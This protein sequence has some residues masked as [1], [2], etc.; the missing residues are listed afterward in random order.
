MKDYVSPVQTPYKGNGGST[1]TIE[2]HP[3]YGMMGLSR[4][5]GRVCLFGSDFVHDRY[6][7]LRIKTADVRRGLSNDWP[8]AHK[9]IIE[10]YLSE[11]QWATFVSSMNVGDGVP[12]TINTLQGTMVPGIKEVTNR[13]AQFTSELQEHLKTAM[14]SL[15][16]LK[17]MIEASKLSGKAKNELLGL[18]SKAHQDIAPNVEFVVEQFD[19]HV[20]RATEQAKVEV[21]TYIQ[22]AMARAGLT[23]EQVVGTPLALEN[24]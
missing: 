20:E 16:E 5:S 8:H 7:A 15:D 12:C 17:A 11:S 24:K 21:A 1:E 18:V 14:S 19:E 10:V 6:I 3:A 23:T 22:S 4:V 13:K 9:E 2:T